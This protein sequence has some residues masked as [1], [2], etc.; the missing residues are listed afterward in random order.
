MTLRPR[1][2]Q[3]VSGGLGLRRQVFWGQ[4]KSEVDLK[5]QKT[6]WEPSWE[7]GR[8]DGTGPEIKSQALN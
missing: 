8:A 7:C 2:P 6:G 3:S 1:V 4:L 5:L